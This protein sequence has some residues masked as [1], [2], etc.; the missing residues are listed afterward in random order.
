MNELIRAQAQAQGTLATYTG[1]VSGF[2]SEILHAIPLALASPILAYQ[3]TKSQKDLLI[4]AIEAKRQ[5]RSKILE[6]MQVLAKHGALTPELSQ[7][8]M[9][10]YNSQPY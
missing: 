3:K 1:G 6:T 5:E 2:V 9:I 7:Q 4:V 10:A 8:L